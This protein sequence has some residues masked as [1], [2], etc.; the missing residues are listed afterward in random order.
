MCAVAEPDEDS[1]S[2]LQN[3]DAAV[4]TLIQSLPTVENEISTAP[5]SEIEPELVENPQAAPPD[6]SSLENSHY[7]NLQ[8]H[9]QR[10]TIIPSD[11][12]SAI[13]SSR[14]TRFFCSIIMA[15]WVIAAYGGLFSLL[16]IHLVKSVVIGF[17]PIYIV[18]LTNWS[19]VAARLFAGR[20]RGFGR[21][22]RRGSDET[23]ASSG[24][25][26]A[27]LAR[28]LEIGLLLQSVLDAVFMDCAVYAIVLVCGLSLLHT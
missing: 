27:Q 17:R 12:S 19:V 1:I 23:L 26:G 28:T 25:W 8:D 7:Q 18:L 10:F 14:G 20:Q 4:E 16:G 21:L 15:M 2:L 24:D 6:S 22:S 3:L 13:N 11:I 5:C 9:E